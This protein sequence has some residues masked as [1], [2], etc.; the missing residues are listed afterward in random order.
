MGIEVDFGP[1][2]PFA[3]DEHSGLPHAP[4]SLPPRNAPRAIEREAEIKLFV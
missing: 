4:V 1:F 3:L 2:L